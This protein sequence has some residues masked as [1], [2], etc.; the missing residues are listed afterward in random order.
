M[1]LPS[2]HQARSDTTSPP[3]RPWIVR[4]R[5]RVPWIVCGLCLI[6][7]LRMDFVTSRL[8]RQLTASQTNR[9]T[10]RIVATDVLRDQ[11]IEILILLDNAQ[12]ASEQNEIDTLVNQ[13]DLAR[14]AI[15]DA[16]ASTELY[17]VVLFDDQPGRHFELGLRNYASAIEDLG[18]AIDQRNAILPADRD[19]LSIMQA[20][21]ELLWSTFSPDLLR[22]G[23]AEDIVTAQTAFCLGTRLHIVLKRA[24]PS[25][26][27]CTPPPLTSQ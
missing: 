6:L 23:R 25:L 7:I 27:T 8:Q 1:T 13:L 12:L 20:D 21:I 18:F 4:W 15:Y 5:P 11:V 2:E 24:A 17:G 22:D 26:A 14:L 16:E 19:H 9:Q 3:G 10:L